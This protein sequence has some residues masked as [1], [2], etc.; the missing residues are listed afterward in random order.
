MF[1]LSLILLSQFWGPA[2]CKAGQDC[3]VKSVITD[4]GVYFAQDV[5]FNAPANCNYTDIGRVRYSSAWSELYYCALTHGAG[6]QAPYPFPFRMSGGYMAA[7]SAAPLLG[8]FE[9]TTI[10]TGVITTGNLWKGSTAISHGAG[11][12]IDGGIG[13][14][15]AFLCQCETNG[16]GAG[17]VLLTLTHTNTNTDPNFCTVSMPCTSFA[18]GPTAAKNPLKCQ[19]SLAYSSD[20]GFNDVAYGMK[21][22]VSGCTTPPAQCTCSVRIYSY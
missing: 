9:A 21:A 19:S 4:G 14:T 12:S 7:N 20:V 8:G 18:M 11:Y 22:D 17:N 5:D 15:E 10:S 6:V 3:A 1:A 2:N 13:I 16:T